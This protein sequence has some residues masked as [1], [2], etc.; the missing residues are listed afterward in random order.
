M[1]GQKYDPSPEDLVGPVAPA[2]APAFDRRWRA[3]LSLVALFAQQPGSPATIAS[4]EDADHN[5][6]ILVRETGE[7]PIEF[8]MRP[9]IGVAIKLARLTRAEALELGQALIRLAL[10]TEAST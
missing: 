5:A 1:G 10:T 4:W 6:A 2:P 3:D 7:K 9:G 8:Y